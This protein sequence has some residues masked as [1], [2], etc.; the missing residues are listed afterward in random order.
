M[1]DR[2][3]ILFFHIDNISQGD[4]GCYGGGFP[5][6][7]TTP[8]I[9]AFASESLLLTNYNVE[10]Q[11]TPTRSALMT[12]RHPIRTGCITALPGSGLVAWEVTVAQP[13]KELGYRN[14][15]FGKWHIGEEPGRYPTDKGFDYWY[16]INGS[17]DQALWPDDRWF[18]KEDIE[19][20]YILESE[21][22]GDLRHI[23][24]LD[25]EVRRN[26]DLDFVDKASEWMEDSISADEPF[27]IYFNHSMIHFPTLP[28]AEYQGSSNGGDAADC[29]QML[30]GDFGTLMA[31]LD[32]LGVKDNTI[33]VVAGDN[34]RDTSF[35]A[36]NNRTA[37]GQWRG[38]YFSTYEGNNRTVGAVRWPG[39][40]EPRQSDE[41]MHVVDWFPTLLNLIGNPDGVPRDRVIDGID[42]SGFVTGDQDGSNRDGFQMYFDSQ[43]VGMRYK[44]FKI[45]THKVEDG[46]SPIQQLAIPHIYNLTLNPDEDTPYA[47]EYGHSWVLYKIF[48]PAVVEHRQSLA[49]DSVPFGAPLDYNPHDRP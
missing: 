48:M 12:G 47:Y 17:W 41:M 36:P 23:K 5:Q 34:G 39:H 30:D 19:P 6:G 20:E 2:P 38:G 3:N 11:C 13:L 26:I 37:S 24:V 7:V 35:H 43:H 42:Q 33:V 10:A 18:Q 22:P 29:I 21:G 25:K 44:N 40:V 15:V 14:A 28:R 49:K 1:A 4:L 45:L 16:G 31:K 8:N 46:A 27:F 32:E 9:D